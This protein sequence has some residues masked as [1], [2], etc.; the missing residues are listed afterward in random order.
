MGLIQLLG[1]AIFIIGYLAIVLEHRLH[2][3]KSAT[4]LIIGCLLWLLTAVSGVVSR[5]ELAHA[6]EAAGAEIF[7]IVAFL[8]AAMTLIEIL[9][10]YNFFDI[11][12]IKL[13]QLKLDDQRQ[14]LLMGL[15]TFFLSAVF[16]NLTITIIMIQIALRFFKKKNLLTAAAGIVVLANAGGVWSPIGDV[17]T[18]MLWLSKKFTAAEIIGYAFLPAVFLGLTAAG[19]LARQITTDTRDIPAEKLKK[20]TRGETAIIAVTLMSFS[21]PLV[22]NLIGLQ[23]YIGLLLGLGTVWL[24]IDYAKIRSQTVT[25]LEANINYFLGKTDIASLKFF[26]GILLAVSALKTM[27]TLEIMSVWLFGAEQTFARIVS[28]SVILGLASAV[29]DNVPL[30]AVAI[31]MIHSGNA[32]LWSLLAL[33]VGT[34]GSVLVV[35]SVAGVVAMG[36]VKELNFNNYLKIAAL[37]ALIGYGVAIGLWYLEYVTISLSI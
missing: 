19:L 17:T 22:M 18:I 16:D 37:P 29:F 9:V 32:W 24:L 8:L 7:S 28:G 10:H 31:D 25:H 20:F 15:M 33:A 11:L 35:G 34:G 5:E 14:F 3:N 26:I 6:M 36:M 2:V 23:P 1:A 30:T 12:R 13:G 27:G 21:L 4:S